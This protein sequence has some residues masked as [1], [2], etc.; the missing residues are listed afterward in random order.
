VTI[1]ERDV[2]VAAAQSVDSGETS[3][4]AADDNDTRTPLPTKG[5]AI[6]ARGRARVRRTRT[7]VVIVELP[8]V[9]GGKE[10]SMSRVA[11]QDPGGARRR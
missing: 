1:D 9:F 6:S 8:S 7:G 5:S 4:A 2:C 11:G 3:K 10:M